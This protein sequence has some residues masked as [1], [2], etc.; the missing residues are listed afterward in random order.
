VIILGGGGFIGS[1]MVKEMVGEGHT[2]YAVDVVFPS[3]RLPQLVGSKKLV[4]DLRTDVTRDILESYQPDYV[5]QFAADM[6]GV[7]YFHSDRDWAASVNNGLINYQVLCAVNS[8]YKQPRLLFTSTACAYATEHQMTAQPANLIE[9][10]IEWGTPDQL[11]GLEKRMSAVMY[12]TAP[13]DARVALLHTT[14]GPFQEYSGIRMKFPSAVCQK[15]RASRTTKKMELLGDGTQIRSFL[16]ITDAISR[17]KALMFDWDTDPGFV[18]VGS[19]TPHRIVDVAETVLSLA[20]ST[21]NHGVTIEFIGGPM[22]VRARNSDNTKA[23]LVFGN[24]DGVSMRDGMARFIE[25]LDEV[26]A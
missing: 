13:L 21:N 14:Y 1:H 8:L 22:G 16:Y 10:D 23:K 3:F 17:L 19:D 11:Y 9:E 18:N 15:A 20:H 7:E 25:W 6:G 5:F 26:K 12:Q 4:A 24:T 2:V